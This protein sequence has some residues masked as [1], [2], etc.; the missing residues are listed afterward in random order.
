MDAEEI[1]KSGSVYELARSGALST[2]TMR[3]LLIRMAFSDTK[4][5]TVHGFRT[6][7]RVWGGAQMATTTDGYEVRRFSDDALEFAIGH[8]VGSTTQRAC[9][10]SDYLSE[11]TA[12][13]KLWGGHVGALVGA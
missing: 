5:L 2:N 8:V 12:L 6:T 13:M 1:G 10:R 7:L 9:N 3:A 11:R 4:L